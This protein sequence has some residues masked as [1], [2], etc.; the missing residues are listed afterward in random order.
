MNLPHATRLPLLLIAFVLCT[1]AAFAWGRTGH[2]AIAALAEANLTPKAKAAI[3]KYLDGR[4]I[5]EFAVWMDEVRDT[6]AYSY[7]GGWHTAPVDNKF[8]HTDSSAKTKGDVITATMDS[9]KTLQKYQKRSKATVALHIKFLV[10]MI[11]D[12]HC[13]GHVGYSHF[14]YGF[15][16]IING[17]PV[18]YHAVWDSRV[19]DSFKLSIPAWVQR[20]NRLSPDQISK[21]VAGAPRDW[22][23]QTAMSSIVI[24]EWGKSGMKMN[25]AQ[26]DDFLKKARPL[27]EMQLQK[28][29]YRLAAVLNSIF[30]R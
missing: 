26:Y 6:P 25:G 15:P 19:V 1:N 28:A 3:D 30:D 16:V 20:L 2:N 27:A 14:D 10:H 18:D 4:S 9:I 21:V 22:F 13:P 29:G 23:H 24:Y 7:S 12:S 17:K 11:G 5:V 8:N